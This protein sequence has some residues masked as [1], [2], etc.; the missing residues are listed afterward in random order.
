MQGDLLSPLLFILFIMELQ[1]NMID[2]A[3]VGG[4][5]SGFVERRNK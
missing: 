2:R 3:A 1:S 4:R 5:L